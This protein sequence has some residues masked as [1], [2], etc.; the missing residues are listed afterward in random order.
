MGSVHS[1][2]QG[3]LRKSSF[4]IYCDDL[5]RQ[6]MPD[7]TSRLLSRLSGVYIV[8]LYGIK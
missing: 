6:V 2:L 7:R 5:M 8:L 1:P 3:G 4:Y